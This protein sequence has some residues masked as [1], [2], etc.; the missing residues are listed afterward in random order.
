MTQKRSAGGA[1][2]DKDL[3]QTRQRRVALITKLLGESEQVLD[4]Y[5]PLALRKHTKAMDELSKA[6]IIAQ[7]NGNAG[8]FAMAYNNAKALLARAG[9]QFDESIQRTPEQLERH[10]QDVESLR[11]EVEQKFFAQKGL[12]GERS[13]LSKMNPAHALASERVFRGFDK[14]NEM[15]KQSPEMVSTHDAK[16]LLSQIEENIEK[17]GVDL[18]QYNERAEQALYNKEENAALNTDEVVLQP[19]LEHVEELSPQEVYK[20]DLEQQF[21]VIAKE[22]VKG[23]YRIKVRQAVAE[24]ELVEAGALDMVEHPEVGLEDKVETLTHVAAARVGL[25]A[26]EKSEQENVLDR[27]R[28]YSS[29]MEE[30]LSI[31]EPKDLS[32]EVEKE[33]DGH[34]L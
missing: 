12:A 33:R 25:E 30:Q 20:K 24:Q 19:D 4:G 15:L 23:V 1:M 28:E 17:S 8:D 32:M 21:D 14:L 27:V 2:S 13:M 11:E 26:P 22:E 29:A 5:N 9:V 16:K 3:E 7:E 31:I 6:N 18:E 10:T 34:S